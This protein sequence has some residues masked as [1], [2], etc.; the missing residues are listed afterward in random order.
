MGKSEIGVS[1]DE[2]RPSGNV[3]TELTDEQK[4][5]CV[6]AEKL[7]LVEQYHVRA[8]WFNETKRTERVVRLGF[9]KAQVHEVQQFARWLTN[10]RP[11]HAWRKYHEC[12][13]ALAKI[14]GCRAEEIETTPTSVV[15]VAR[16][17]QV[18]HGRGG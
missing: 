16:R 12:R 2:P 1:R 4:W 8:V 5:A 3:L 14:L 17:V 6:F 9:S 7:M 18:S 15:M 11:R 10:L 13:E